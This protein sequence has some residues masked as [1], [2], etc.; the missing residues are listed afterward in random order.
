LLEYSQNNTSDDKNSCGALASFAEQAGYDGALI[1]TDQS[2][3]PTCEV[4]SISADVK[5][6][7]LDGMPEAV[8]PLADNNGIIVNVDDDQNQLAGSFFIG[9]QSLLALADPQ[10]EMPLSHIALRLGN[11]DI[12]IK[13]LPIRRKSRLQDEMTA[14]QTIL[15][16]QLVMQLPKQPRVSPN[17]FLRI[18]LVM[19]TVFA[20]MIGW[21]IVNQMLLQPVKALQKKMRNYGPGNI[22]N[23]LPVTKMMAPE[24]RELDTAFDHLAVKVNDD[25]QAIADNLDEQIKLTREV[26]HRVKNNLQ[27]ITSLLNL[28]SRGIDDQ[29]LKDHYRMVQRRVD[30]L[31]VVHRNHFAQGEAAYGIAL[32]DLITEILSSFR[33]RK[34][35][36]ITA[37][38]EIKCL[39]HK[40]EQDTAMP[41]AFLLTELMEVAETLN[42]D[43]NSGV[44]IEAS[45][46]TTG[47]TLYLQLS[48]PLFAGEKAVNA[49]G[50]TNIDKVITGLCRQ[51]RTEL[52][53]DVETGSIAITIP[54]IADGYTSTPDGPK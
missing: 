41:V 48:S 9:Q 31:A 33:T 30:A 12:F 19:M 51:L 3:V 32:R 42:S 46:R 2:G 40:V 50:Q 25:K 5:M 20:A 21:V 10:D 1:F 52:V 4:G 26:H 14:A 15:G 6:Q 13:E 36:D 22:I 7:M 24:I 53:H 35:D 28:H 49:L 23:P 45:P 18:L 34:G 37:R 29:K 17:Y 47:T 44:I 43:S 16:M 38:T 11:K 8:Q 54:I 39:R 27:I